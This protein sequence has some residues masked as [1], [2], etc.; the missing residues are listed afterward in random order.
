MLKVSLRISL[1]AVAM[2]VALAST[3][4]AEDSKLIKLVDFVREKSQN[5]CGDRQSCLDAGVNF[6]AFLWKHRDKRN[7]HKDTIA[8]VGIVAYR[9]GYI[10][11]PMKVL[12]AKTPDDFIRISADVC[13][14]VLERWGDKPGCYPLLV[15]TKEAFQESISDR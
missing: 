1:P 8:C 5:V 4:H 13:D 12:D 7:V 3:V 9:R 14:C 11:A 2:L 10:V 15:G 6:A